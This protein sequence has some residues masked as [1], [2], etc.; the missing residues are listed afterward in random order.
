M[1]NEHIRQKILQILAEERNRKPSSKLDADTLI[2]R[3]DVLSWDDIQHEITY[4]EEKAYVKVNYR[5]LGN[6]IFTTLHITADGIDHIEGR[7]SP[8]TAAGGTYHIT[9]GGQGHKFSIGNQSQYIEGLSSSP[10]H[11]QRD[12]GPATQP[13]EPSRNRLSQ[14]HRKLSRLFDEGEL[15]TL[16]FNL[17]IDYED[18]PGQGKSNKARELIGYLNRRERIEELEEMVNWLRPNN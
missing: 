9:I 3:L 14:L 15:R 7:T 16:C 12:A 17:D 10:A 1:K 11:Q 5:Q 4:L 2:E 6:R 13:A 18:L 8:Q